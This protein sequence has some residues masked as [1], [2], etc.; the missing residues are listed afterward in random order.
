MPT[1]PDD[2]LP[3]H[4]LSSPL[5]V[6]DVEPGLAHCAITGWRHEIVC[7]TVAFGHRLHEIRAAIQHPAPSWVQYR[8]CPPAISC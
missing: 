2:L 8:Q 6:G 1:S 5:T 3:A 4:R 7:G